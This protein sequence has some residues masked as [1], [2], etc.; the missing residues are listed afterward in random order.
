MC[1]EARDPKQK[2]Q[3]APPK[4]LPY[5]VNGVELLD[6]GCNGIDITLRATH[7]LRHHD[8]RVLH[9][10]ALTLGA[11]CLHGDR[12][13]AAAAAGAAAAATTQYGIEFT[14]GVP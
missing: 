6:G 11:S 3:P 12:T 7:G 9:A 4:H 13:A 5:L 2:Q 10:V 14:A 1:P 8:T